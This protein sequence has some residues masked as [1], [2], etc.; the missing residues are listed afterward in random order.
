MAELTFKSP[1]VSTREI[2]LS[3]PTQ[4]GP[5]GIPAG[6]IGT[7]KQGRA[8]VPITVATFADFVAEFG[9]TD[10]TEFGPLAMRQWL[11]YANAGTYVRTLGAGDAKKRNANGTVTNAGFV[12]GEELVNQTT[13]Q[14]AN[15]PFA[16]PNDGTAAAATLTAASGI[17]IVDANPAFNFGN[18]LGGGVGEITLQSISHIITIVV[19]SFAASG[20][21]DTFTI[22][23]CAGGTDGG[24]DPAASGDA[25]TINIAINNG[26][27]GITLA[28]TSVRDII[29]SAINGT[30]DTRVA[31]SADMT[32][33]A[34]SGIPGLT[35]SST[36]TVDLALAIDT[37]GAEGNDAT[38]KI[39]D[40]DGA[41]A[42]MTNTLTTPQIFSANMAD[43]TAVSFT[44]GESLKGG[45]GRTHF[46]VAMMAQTAGSTI[47][48][49]A[50]L[51]STQPIIR[52]VLLAPSGVNIT[53]SSSINGGGGYVQNNLP[54][55]GPGATNSSAAFVLGPKKAADAGSTIGDVNIAAGRQEF[56]L[57]QNGHTHT[58]ANPTVVTASFDPEAPNYFGTILN[59]DPNKL[60]EAG[61]LLYAHYDIHPSQAVVTA[62]GKV[63]QNPAV[64]SPFATFE[65]VKEGVQIKN[66]PLAFLLTGSNARNVGTAKVPN[67]E[68]FQDR[69]RT[70]KFPAFISQKFGGEN[71]DL[72]T[73]HCLDD[74]AIG[75]NRVKVSIENINKS[76]N[77]NNKFGTFDLLV[78]DYYD[79]DTNPK[80]LE[81]FNKLSL[82]PNDERYVSR[83]IGDYHIFYDFDKR[84]GGQKLV[85]EGSYPN[86]SNYVR[87]AP[88]VVLE[89][90]E[91]PAEALPVGFRGP[92]HLV[93]SG[94][95]GSNKLF[96]Q[97]DGDGAAISKLKTEVVSQTV[98]A[99][100]PFRRTIAQGQSPK[101]RVNSSLY[102]GVQTTRVTSLAEP[103][104][105]TVF[106]ESI[107]SF[108]VYF[109]D[110]LTTVQA[111]SVGGNAGVADVG[112]IVL[113]SDRFNNSKFSLENIQVIT[114]ADDKADAEQWAAA[115]YRRDGAKT[116]N[117]NDI[118]GTSTT[119]TRLLSVEK[120]FGLLSARKFLRFTALPQ[121]GFDGLNPFD[122]Q[123]SKMSDEAIRRE[124]T[125]E[126]QGLIN[127][128]TVA[129]FRKAVDVLG[130]R[131]DVDIQLLA[132]P[133]I[134]QPAVTD[135]AINTV[136][137]RF[138]AM[139]IMDIP[140]IDTLGTPVSGSDQDVSVIQSATTFGARN[141]DSSFAAAYFPDV[142]LEDPNTGAAAQ[143]PPSVAVLG[144]FGLNDS[145]AFP[146]FAPAGFT[147][148]ALKG[149]LETQVKLNRDNLDTLYEVDVNPL[150]SFPQTSDVVVFGQKTLL[151]AQS[152]LDRVNVRRL[153]IDIRR[154]VRKVGDTFLFEPNRESTLAKFSAAVTPILTRIQAQQGLERF[155]VQIDTTTTTQADIENNTV[156]GKIF[157]Q[158]VRSV[159]FISLDF[160]VTN[161]GLDI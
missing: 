67:V 6:V 153:L 154:Q 140:V 40:N 99:P 79:E 138:D 89:N 32:D 18:A 12:A 29:K 71:K 161:A 100:L 91:V 25:K 28:G 101:K 72:F 152:A 7:A 60:Q 136:E 36:G 24:E 145:V 53:L 87:V 14:I 33:G 139:Y 158:P 80:V 115:N 150:T 13:G 46:L 116:T 30:A 111:L 120:D 17:T 151:A 113:D 64:T 69:F 63:T 124:M 31:Y 73:I 23:L 149:V 52:G 148:G 70:A 4:T 35:A 74:G 84:E 132:I 147:R 26:S 43:D 127:G 15:N 82:N 44:G 45:L 5:S 141:L 114:T 77:V 110:H 76:T 122:L 57:L 126:D 103:N 66:E 137:E 144:A 58:A 160:V 96:K 37:A 156:R 42:D 47:F 93:T 3:G 107:D 155:K 39:K 119:Q 86:A 78:R 16:G 27:S 55:G 59:K 146:W 9:D 133:G 94:S 118:D 75:N 62:S 48:T 98:Q 128:P 143:V 2:D 123:K 104:S 51:D 34:T 19:P 22:N 10:S 108:G 92:S 121:G 11:S 41:V 159:E 85:V 105:S 38:I 61:H 134:R 65:G 157:L 102:W 88:S 117:M 83:V 109:P 68:N 8:F 1:G 20:V 142:I 135:F 97:I 50:G 131:S 21:D 90:G 129:A 106:N 56:V 49:E 95:D 54:F 125:F 130:E 112:G 81:R